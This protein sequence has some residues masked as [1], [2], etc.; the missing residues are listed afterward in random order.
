MSMTVRRLVDNDYSFGQGRANLASNLEAVL[1]RC[2]TH[3]MQ[4]QGEWFL[5]AGDGTPWFD[6]IGQRVDQPLLE[7]T[8]RDRLLSVED[9]TAVDD[10]TVLFDSD[11]R[12]VGVLCQVMTTFGAA[13]LSEIINILS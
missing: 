8:V 4:F 1:Q 11:T 13:N 3:L 2:K 6:V 5:N 12:H 10:M 9:V 7:R